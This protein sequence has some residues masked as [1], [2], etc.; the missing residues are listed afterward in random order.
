MA[1]HGP[2]PPGPGGGGAVSETVFHISEAGM[3]HT[4]HSIDGPLGQSMARLCNRITTTA[5]GYAPVDTGLMRSRIEFTI[6]HDGDELMGVIAA[7]TDYSLY[8]HEGTIYT[9]PNPFLEDAAAV[10][11]G[12]GLT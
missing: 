7:R 5:K 10:E 1:G 8:V 9:E 12:R 4:F 3:Q 6:E 11:I 2:A